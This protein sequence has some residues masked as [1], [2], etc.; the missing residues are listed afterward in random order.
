MVEFDKVFG[1]M[2]VVTHPEVLDF[3]FNLPFR[4]VRSEVRPELRNEFVVVIDPVGCRV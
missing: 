3:C 2:L 1:D 4:V